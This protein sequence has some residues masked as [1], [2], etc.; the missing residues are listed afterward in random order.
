MAWRYGEEHPQ[1]RV[2][3][4]KER[5]AELEQFRRQNLGKRVRFVVNGT[6]FQPVQVKP[7][8]GDLTA[9]LRTT[10]EATRMAMA[11]MERDQ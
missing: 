7:E 11:L 1:L 4:F 5:Q 6:V 8:T 9:R 3:L 2:K 10:S